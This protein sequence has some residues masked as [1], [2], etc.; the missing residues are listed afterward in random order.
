MRD[1]GTVACSATM[2]TSSGPLEE[3]EGSAYSAVTANA[4]LLPAIEPGH[5]RP[6]KV[7]AC[8]TP[9]SRLAALTDRRR[10]GLGSPCK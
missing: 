5:G 1:K 7:G 6:V 8:R 10:P 9:A 4:S 3:T 2:E